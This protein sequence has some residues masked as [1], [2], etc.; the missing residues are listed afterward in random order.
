VRGL[1]RTEAMPAH[2]HRASAQ[3]TAASSRAFNMSMRVRTVLAKNSIQLKLGRSCSAGGWLCD[4][5]G[6]KR[7]AHILTHTCT[8]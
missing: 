8:A 3:A 1:L 7:W 2:S 6:C 4:A 5:D